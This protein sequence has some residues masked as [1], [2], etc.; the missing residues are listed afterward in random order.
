MPDTFTTNLNLDQ[1]AV[2]ADNDTWGGIL[3]NDL[4]IIDNQFGASGTGTVIRRDSSNRATNGDYALTKAA[5]N[6]RGVYFLTG[7]GN[8]WIFEANADAEGGS[9]VGSDLA[10]LRYADDGST[11][12]GTSLLIERESGQVT[13]ETTP[14]VSGNDVWSDANASTKLAALTGFWTTGDVKLTIKTTADSGWIMCNDGTIGNTSSGATYANA[15]AQNLYTLLWNNISNTDAPVTGGRGANAAADWTAQK[16]IAL[17]KM[18][19][20]ALA[21]A[22]TGAGLSARNLGD[23]VGEETHL[24]SSGEMP[25]HSHT[26]TVTDPGHN[27]TWSNGNPITGTGGAAGSSGG[28]GQSTL[29]QSATTGITVA[30]ANTGGGGAHNN[31]QPTSFLNAMIKL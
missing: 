31:M 23:T 12:L 19:G 14:Q 15:N 21:L 9:N 17:T 4:L 20:R 13:F 7:T 30:N 25:S 18:L 10:L 6:S 22:G 5:G 8:R 16:P 2:G 26:A 24:L 11:L 28:L 1:P 3:N 27:H 29:I